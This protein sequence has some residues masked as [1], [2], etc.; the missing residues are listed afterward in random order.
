MSLFCSLHQAFLEKMHTHLQGHPNLASHLSNHG[1]R[2]CI[3]GVALL[4]V[5]LDHRTLAKVPEQ[6]WCEACVNHRGQSRP[7]RHIFE[8]QHLTLWNKGRWFSSCLSLWEVIKI[9]MAHC[10]G[11]CQQPLPLPRQMALMD[12]GTLSH[13]AL[14][15]L[16]GIRTNDSG[17]F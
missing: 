5:H 10:G 8:K 2:H 12:H 3:R 15:V 14:R 4:A 13:L 7:G 17:R 9:R 6:R 1:L 16:K 11:G